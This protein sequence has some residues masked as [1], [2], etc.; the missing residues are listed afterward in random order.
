M[1]RQALPAD[2]T[3]ARPEPGNRSNYVGVVRS[4]DHLLQVWLS[5]TSMPHLAPHWS[6]RTVARPRQSDGS[7]K[8]APR[9]HSI[10]S[11]SSASR[12]VEANHSKNSTRRSG[13]YALTGVSPREWWRTQHALKALDHHE[14]TS[15]TVGSCENSTVTLERDAAATSGTWSSMMPRSTTGPA[16]PIGAGGPK[17]DR[18]VPWR[19]TV[20]PLALD[21]ASLQFSDR[22]DPRG[23]GHRVSVP[24]GKPVGRARV[25]GPQSQRPKPRFGRFG[26][27]RRHDQI[28]SVSYL[29]QPVYRQASEAKPTDAHSGPVGTPTDRGPENQARRTA[30]R[31]P[32]QDRWPCRVA[33]R[34]PRHSDACPHRSGLPRHTALCTSRGVD[35]PTVRKCAVGS[36]QRSSPGCLSASQNA[37]PRTSSEKH[38]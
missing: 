24:F 19:R 30:T 8:A 4:I 37:C 32:H 2:R 25:P 21:V 35:E 33:R 1:L 28:D 22:V 38:G 23:C 10:G 20:P 36:N 14:A 11:G 6:H 15:V 26:P 9:S 7:T 16:G 5:L 3:T 13:G 27:V 18:V 34:A 12:S 31:S 17:S 29:S